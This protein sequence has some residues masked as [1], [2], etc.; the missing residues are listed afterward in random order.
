MSDDEDR[1]IASLFDERGALRDPMLASTHP[2]EGAFVVFGQR[3]D[4]AIDEAAARSNARRFFGADLTLG[5]DREPATSHP[6]VDAR[7]L[8]LTSDDPTA[9]GR[10][11][12]YVRPAAPAD[13]ARAE[14]AEATAAREGQRAG[15][16]SD[17]ARRCPYAWLV[18]APS[19][20]D[21][22]ALTLAAVLATVLLGPI[23]T[24][25]G[26]R[27]FG[28]RGARMALEAAPPGYR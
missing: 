24:P 5:P 13:H 3:A 1:V 15:G 11:V 28:V 19:D 25:S 4:S 18:L 21:R 17:L 7:W 6:E 8:R 27:I 26:R 20:D 22:V 2:A 10:R 12:V 16:L 9:S 14:D 23:V